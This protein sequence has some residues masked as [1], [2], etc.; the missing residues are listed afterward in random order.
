M[1]HA[2]KGF[3]IVTLLT[4]LL[5]IATGCGSPSSPSGEDFV[6]AAANGDT[7]TVQA[8]LDAG[9][10]V[11]A[12]NNEGVTALMWAAGVGGTDAVQVLLDAGADVNAKHKSGTA[13]VWAQKKGHTEVVEILKKAGAKK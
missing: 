13:L 10:D 11:N 2:C 7:A 6:T 8:L 9:A 1:R 4:P 12:K 3:L 5:L